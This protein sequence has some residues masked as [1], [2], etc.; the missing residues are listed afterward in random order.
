[1]PDANTPPPAEMD[2]AP[3]MDEADARVHWDRLHLKGPAPGTLA[4]DFDLPVI[5]SDD[6]RV[7][8]AAQRG[9]PVALIFGSYT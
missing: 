1:M 9:R 6:E 3:K 5:D 7:Q 8:L 4:P 2:E